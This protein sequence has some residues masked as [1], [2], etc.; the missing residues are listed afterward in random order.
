LKS[1]TLAEIEILLQS[2]SKSLENYPPMPLPDS[3]L[4]PDRHNRLIFDEL[5]YD[6]RSLVDEHR[7]LMSTMTNEQRRIYD[8]IMKR[9]EENRQG[10][11]FLYGYGGSGKTYIWRA[12][13]AA[14]R[15]KGEIV[16]TVASSGIAALLIPGGRTAHSRF[17]IPINVHETSTCEIPASAT[18]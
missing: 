1:Y 13:S 7:K 5:N 12:M 3:A 10:L 8:R 6:R 9:V 15:S 14:L 11:F 16:L 17:A 4:I 18:K 2:H